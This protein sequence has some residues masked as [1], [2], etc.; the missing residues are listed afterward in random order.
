MRPKVLIFDNAG[1]RRD[2]AGRARR[3]PRQ[4]GPLS[5]THPRSLANFFVR[6]WTPIP[7]T[8]IDPRPPTRSWGKGAVVRQWALAPTDIWQLRVTRPEDPDTIGFQEGH[9]IEASRRYE[10][11]FVGSN[12]GNAKV[13]LLDSS[14]TRSRSL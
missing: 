1:R 14:D 13:V 7:E 2:P 8:P 5:A 9:H 3:W 12:D 10:F 11:I 6:V 4:L